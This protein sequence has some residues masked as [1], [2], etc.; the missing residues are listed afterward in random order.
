MHNFAGKDIKMNRR[1]NTFK[2]SKLIQEWYLT[3]KRELPW[4]NKTDPYLIWISE[5][6][7]QQTRVAQGLNYYMRFIKRFPDV[8]SLAIAPQ[9]DVLKLWQGLGYYSR[10]RNL[11]EAA[12]DIEKRFNGIFPSAY[13][14][15]RS[16]KGIGEYTAAAIASFAWNK[17]FPVID[18]N[19]LRVLGRLFAIE[20]PI[21]SGKGKKEF[22][23]LATLLMPPEQAG[24]HNQAIMEFGALQCTPKNP[25]CT[26]CPLI[27]QCAGHASGNPQQYPVKKHKTKTRHRYFNY[28]FITYGT[29]TYLSRR[30]ENDIWK[31]LFELPLIETGQPYNLTELQETELFKKLFQETGKTVFSSVANGM[32]HILSHQTLHVNCYIADIQKENNTLEKLI[33]TSRKNM[34]LY[35]VPILIANILSKIET[36]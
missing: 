18:G 32:R 25:S 2:E 31:G 35:P 10:A 3:N 19:V 26:I 22:R 20:T 27:E 34:H 15:I 6:I 4:R 28:F 29:N 14:D 30:T 17:P 11:H 1:N 21:D 24:L 5:I 16:L 36:N 7:L 23:Q 12:Q 9:E 8:H 33:R 13:E